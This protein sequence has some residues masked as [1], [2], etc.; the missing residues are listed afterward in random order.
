MGKVRVHGKGPL[1]DLW[2]H[3]LLSLLPFLGS[4]TGVWGEEGSDWRGQTTLVS[5]RALQQSPN[6]FPSL[7]HWSPSPILY[8]AAWVTIAKCKSAMS[9][10]SL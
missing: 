3:S 2:G 8:K 6:W 4:T 5:P 10:P 9:L 7:Q 1:W